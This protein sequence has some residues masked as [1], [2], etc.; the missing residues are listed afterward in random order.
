M[1]KV[2]IQGGR[3][4]GPTAG[5]T[6]SMT[7]QLDQNRT[8][9]ISTSVILIFIRHKKAQEAL[10]C[11]IPGKWELTSQVPRLSLRLP[12]DFEKTPPTPPARK[13]G[14]LLSFRS[15]DCTCCAWSEAG[16]LSILHHGG[17]RQLTSSRRSYSGP[18][19]RC[20]RPRWEN[21]APCHCRQRRRN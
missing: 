10:V 14:E 13:P 8:S 12:Q 1:L 4:Q 19:R 20:C 16:N 3:I 15:R 2:C 18:S 7:R 5:S 9:N 6:T 21:H 17:S 11:Q